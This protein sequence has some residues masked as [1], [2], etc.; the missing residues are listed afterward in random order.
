[1][2]DPLDPFGSAR[3]RALLEDLLSYEFRVVSERD[4]IVVARRVH[5][6]RGPLGEMPPDGGCYARTSLDEFQ[7]LRPA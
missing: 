6:P 4:G 5:P 3:S 2:K 7:P 1:M